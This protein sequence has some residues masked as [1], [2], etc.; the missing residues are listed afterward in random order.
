MAPIPNGASASSTAVA[1]PSG[2][3]RCD[4]CRIALNASSQRASTVAAM[5]RSPLG[6]PNTVASRDPPVTPAA[7]V[8]RDRSN[9]FPSAPRRKRAPR[10][11]R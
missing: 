10:H 8:T 6:K 9:G 5:S 4:P 2:W 7:R 3:N 11:A 1:N